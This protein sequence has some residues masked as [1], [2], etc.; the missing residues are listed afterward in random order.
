MDETND[1]EASQTIEDCFQGIEDTVAALEAGELPLD[2]A[3]KRYEAAL[4]MVRLARQHLDR[5]Q[6][7][8]ETLR[9]DEAVADAAAE[10]DT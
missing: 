3:F 6:A 9:E 4:G 1:A 5:F 8:L 7:R 2:Q 10:Y